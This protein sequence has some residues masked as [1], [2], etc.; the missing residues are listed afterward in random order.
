MIAVSDH[1][2]RTADDRAERREEAT[3][4]AQCEFTQEPTY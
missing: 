2:C 3:R 4:I 1:A